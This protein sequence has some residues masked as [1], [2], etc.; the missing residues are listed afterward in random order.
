MISAISAISEVTAFAVL[1]AGTYY[2]VL[3]DEPEPNA[4]KEPSEQPANQGG[5]LGLSAKQSFPTPVATKPS[6]ESSQSAPIAPIPQLD[7]VGV[8]ISDYLETADTVP[9]ARRVEEEL[10]WASSSLSD[11]SDCDAVM[12]V[13]AAGDVIWVEGRLVANTAELGSLPARVAKSVRA[14]VVLVHGNADFP[15]LQDS[16]RCVAVLPIGKDGAVLVL[17]SEDTEFF[18]TVEKRVAEAV[19]Q[20]L[21]SFLKVPPQ[22]GG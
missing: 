15:F 17:A 3:R 4:S 13:D 16:V 7:T 21:A 18:G 11:L 1:A 10:S 14:E 12:I 20:R 22:I 2:F 8:D 19:C 6:S 5:I 9:S